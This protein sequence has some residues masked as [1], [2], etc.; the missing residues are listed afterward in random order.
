[1]TQEIKILLVIFGVT[2]ILTVGGIFFLG[3]S[4][5]P[6]TKTQVDSNVLGALNK[7]DSYQISS[8]SSKVTVVEFSDL[9]CPACAAAHPITKKI[10]EEYKGRIRF[11]YRHFPLPQH[12]KALIAIKAAEA[13]GE[14]GKF[15]EMQDRLFTTQEEWSGKDNA[16]ELFVGYAKD[17]GLDTDKFKADIE[18]GKYNTKIERD[19]QDGLTLQVNSTPTFFIND[20]RYPGVLPYDDFKSKLDAQLE[21]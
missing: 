20:Q 11:V 10:L 9:E 19:R 8:D 4:S 15:W 5:S 3:K 12:T 13:A 16:P 18:S 14:Q 17:L 6:A 7:D 1:M 2:A 21:E